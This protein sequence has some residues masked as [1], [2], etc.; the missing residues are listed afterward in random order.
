MPYALLLRSTFCLDL[1]RSAHGRRGWAEPLPSWEGLG[2][3]GLLLTQPKQCA[4]H[5][6][7]RIEIPPQV[8]L[9]PDGGATG[10]TRWV[11]LAHELHFPLASRSKAKTS[12]LR[13]PRRLCGRRAIKRSDWR[14]GRDGAITSAAVSRSALLVH[15]LMAL[16]SARTKIRTRQKAGPFFSRP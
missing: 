8:P 1:P 3:G 6:A 4:G 16:M 2:L 15:R 5:P 14:G 12:S 10:G 13:E 9:T 11:V 7:H